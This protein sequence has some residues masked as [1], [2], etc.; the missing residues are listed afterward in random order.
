MF[1]VRMIRRRRRRRVSRR[2][3]ARQDEQR[4]AL[5]AEARRKKRLSWTVIIRVR[6]TVSD[7][8]EADDGSSSAL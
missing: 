5:E 8:P 6:L 3:R 2:T 1:I 7:P 4:R